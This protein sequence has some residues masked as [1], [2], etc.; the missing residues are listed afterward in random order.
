MTINI[1]K[2][3]DVKIFAD[4][5]YK[6]Y[7]IS[8]DSLYQVNGK[9][10]RTI[11]CFE[12]EFK[13]EDMPFIEGDSIHAKN[14]NFEFIGSGILLIAEVVAADKST[15][16]KLTKDADHYKVTKP[17]GYEIWING[18]YPLYCFKKIFIKQGTQT[19][20]QYH[21]FKEETN[22][23]MKGNASLVFKENQTIENDLVQPEDLGKLDFNEPTCLHIT[24]KTIHRLKAVTDLLLFEVS[25][26][27]LDD[28]IRIQDD[29]K[30]VDGRI[31]GE[32][33]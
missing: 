27:F 8:V 23:I 18:D 30:R 13:V 33:K 1:N 9:F 2:V 11:I 10:D 29:T 25:T 21:N 16:L 15:I 4:C 12:G 3:K 28:V 5:T 22:V 32:H 31:A 20:L 17:W 7:P 14:I 26:P 6:Y 24:P 19:S